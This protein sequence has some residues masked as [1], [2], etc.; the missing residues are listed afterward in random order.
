MGRIA[1]AATQRV[2]AAAARLETAGTNV[3]QYIEKWLQKVDGANGH[4]DRKGGG[5][6]PGGWGVVD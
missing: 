4:G 1:I 6:V 3:L 5:H 2:C